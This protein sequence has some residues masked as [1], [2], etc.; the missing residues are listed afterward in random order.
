M[1]LTLLHI[2][3]ISSVLQNTPDP[4]G[5]GAEHIPMLRRSEPLTGSGVYEIPVGTDVTDYLTLN[6]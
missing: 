5:G 2:A 3:L 4:V 1:I 6:L